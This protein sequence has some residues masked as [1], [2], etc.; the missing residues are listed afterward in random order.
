MFLHRSICHI[1]ENYGRLYVNPLQHNDYIRRPIRPGPVEI[2]VLDPIHI[3]ITD[4]VVVIE[5]DIIVRSTLLIRESFQHRIAITLSDRQ[6]HGRDTI[7]WI[8]DD[9]AHILPFKI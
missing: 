9:V 2:E 7:L 1:R 3:R 6:N 5:V 8:V 4:M